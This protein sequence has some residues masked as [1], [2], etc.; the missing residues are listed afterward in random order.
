MG[1]RNRSGDD[2]GHRHLDIVTADRS[3]DEVMIGDDLMKSSDNYTNT[4]LSAVVTIR[5][6]SFQR[7]SPSSH[8]HHPSKTRRIYAYSGQFLNEVGL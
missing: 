2:L 1:S 4:G 8:R 5:T 3:G 7:S 6:L